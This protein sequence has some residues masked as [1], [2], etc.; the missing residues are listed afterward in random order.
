MEHGRIDLGFAN[1]DLD[2][3]NMERLHVRLGV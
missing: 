3:N 1:S 2:P